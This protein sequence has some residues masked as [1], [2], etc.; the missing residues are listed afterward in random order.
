[1]KKRLLSMLLAAVMLLALLT[2]CNSNSTPGSS[3][4][5]PSD[6]DGQSNSSPSSETLVL[7]AG[8]VLTEDSAYHEGLLQWAAEVEEKTEGRIHI[9]VFAN[10]ILGNERDLIEALQTNT[11]DITLPNSAPLSN[12]TE[13]FR[14]FD[15]P[16]LFQNREEA[17][18]VIDS[19]IGDNIDP[20][21]GYFCL[22]G[23][24]DF[25]ARKRRFSFEC[26]STLL[27]R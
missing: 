15:L 24:I 2:A 25:Q 19:E 17:Y 3:N 22:T 7:Q 27:E 6:T 9:D 18:K 5:S 12:F 8:H 16:F 4:T 26:A 21:W 23:K 11:L 20:A 10:S 14:V 13:A 1:M